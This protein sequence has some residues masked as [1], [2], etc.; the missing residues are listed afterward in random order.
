MPQKD[1]V[2]DRIIMVEFNPELLE[3][4]GAYNVP[5]LQWSKPG[6]IAERLGA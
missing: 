2:V 1:K 5:Y 3:A 6:L 4:F